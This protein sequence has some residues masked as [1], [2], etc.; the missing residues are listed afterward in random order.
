MGYKS[1]VHFSTDWYQF[2]H[3]R[4]P[5]GFG[6]WAFQYVDGDGK[7]TGQAF[8]FTGNFGDAKKAAAAH[9]ANLNRYS[10][11]VLS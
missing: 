6:A 9:F 1:N 2:A 4:K 11:V 10:V 5:R 8:W 7:H 3:G